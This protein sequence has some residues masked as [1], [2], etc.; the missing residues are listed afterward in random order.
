MSNADVLI[1]LIGAEHGGQNR[2]EASA[3]AARGTVT[4]RRLNQMLLSIRSLWRGLNRNEK[5]ARGP[6]AEAAARLTLAVVLNAY[7]AF[8]QVRLAQLR[9]AP[10][11][12]SQHLPAAQHSAGARTPGDSDSD[13]STANLGTP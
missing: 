3:S 8:G 5:G 13:V 12:Q 10:P 4:G 2:P 9:A 11:A 1:V 6:D 7:F